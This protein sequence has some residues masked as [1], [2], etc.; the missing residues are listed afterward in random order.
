MKK[1]TL[2]R[3]ILKLFIFTVLPYSSY[4]Q[5]GT[6]DFTFGNGGKVVTPIGNNNDEGLSMT[7]QKDGKI[8]VAGFSLNGTGNDY[9]FA[10]VRYNTDGSLDYKFG[11]NGKVVTPIGNSDD[12][13]F[14]V[15]MQSDGNIVIAGQSYNGNDYDF[16]LVRY[17]IDGSL[18]YKFGTNGKVV[19]PIGNS[20]NIGYSDD[21]GNSL[22]IQIDGKIVVAGTSANFSN[23]SYDFSIV[24]YNTDGSLDFTFGNNGKVITP[25][26]NYNDYVHSLAIQTDGKIVVAGTSLNGSGNKAESNF[27]LVRYNTDGSL[28]DTFGERGKVVSLIKNFSGSGWSVVIQGD[29]KIVLTGDGNSSSFALMR[30]NTNGSLDSNFGSGGKVITPIGSFDNYGRSATIQSDNKIIVAG[31]SF[32]GI[33]YDFALVRYNSNGSLDSNFGSSGK[34][35]TSIGFDDGGNSLAIQN[36]GKILVV[37]SSNKFGNTFDFAVVRFNNDITNVIDLTTIQN[38]EFNL[39]PNPTNEIINIHLEKE[40]PINHN[41][42]V[43]DLLGQ[44]VLENKLVI[45]SQNFELNLGTLSSGVYLLKVGENVQRVVKW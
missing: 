15:A 25:I 22:A 44:K 12:R 36:D 5:A 35:I 2:L 4:S 11:S 20:K 21:F 10:L 32:N 3:I 26:G 18:D 33:D 39:Y 40:S 41:I 38:A 9:D 13:G 17:K 19:T 43:F 29:G 7:I 34:V 24:R 45:G 28:D 27:A 23:S 30:Y 14:A 16:A 42:Q 8:I 6:L 37:G 1:Y 31:N